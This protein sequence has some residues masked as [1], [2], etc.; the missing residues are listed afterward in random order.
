MR[1]Y[2]QVRETLEL[3]A[4]EL[5]KPHL[6]RED[7]EEMLA[8]NQSM[9]YSDPAR[10]DNRL[11]EYIVEK[12]GNHYI[13]DFFRQHVSV[14]YRALFDYAAPETSVVAE[15]AGQ[16]SRILEALIARTWTHA[17][18]ALMEHIQSQERVLARLL[19]IVDKKESP[20]RQRRGK[21]ARSS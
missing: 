7:L 16:H 15:M 21:T 20:S 13:R 17:R 3:K 1:S 2:L 18:L 4:L 9:D 14:Y 19:T 5:A 6:V 8:G 12:S 10:L 11:H